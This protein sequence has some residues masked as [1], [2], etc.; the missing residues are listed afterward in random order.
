MD[1]SPL[2]SGGK[3]IG[4]LLGYFNRLIDRQRPVLQPVAQRSP[5]TNSM[6]IQPLLP[7]CSS[8]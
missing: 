8:P 4:D 6:T 5:S 1:D 2:V 3:R 7:S